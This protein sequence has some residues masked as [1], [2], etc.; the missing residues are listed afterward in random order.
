MPSLA[1]TTHFIRNQFRQLPSLNHSFAGQTVIVVGANVGLGFEA[2]VHYVRLGAEKVIITVRSQEKGNEAKRKIEERTGKQ[3]VVEAWQLDLSNYESV[4]S[5]AIKA[6]GLPRI[7]ILLEN[8]GVALLDFKTA[9]GS[10][11]TMAVN[12]YGTFLLAML[13][14]PLLQKSA[15]T[16]DTKP[17][18][19]IVSSE[20][21]HFTDFKEAEREDIVATLDDKKFFNGDER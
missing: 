14:F 2:A 3:G 17:V 1:M 16:H 18:L 10:E 9:E 5:F 20:V 15:K 21:H 7:D 12:V 11:L 4:K 6:E 8:A 13:M 19:T